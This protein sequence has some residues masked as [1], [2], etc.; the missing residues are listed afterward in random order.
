M[1]RIVIVNTQVPFI[2]GGAEIHAENLQKALIVH[3]FQVEMIRVPFKWYP[4]EKIPEQILACRLF[5]LIESCGE[6]INLLI[7][8]KFPGYYIKHPNKVLWILHQHRPVYD[9]WNT[10]YRDIPDNAEG[11]EI[12]DIIIQSDKN[13]LPEAKKIFTNSKNV[14]SRLKKFNNLD[15]IPLYHPPNNFNKFFSNDFGNYIFYPSRMST[16]KRQELAIE[17]MRF[18]KT[19]VRLILTGSAESENL[20]NFL[21]KGVEKYNLGSKVTFTGSM[22]EDEKIRIYSNAL[23]V[24]FIP[25]DEDY[26]Y[27]T[28][29]AMYSRKPVITCT[30]SGGPLEFVE[31]D[32]TGYIRN[33]VPEEI[34]DAMDKLYLEREKAKKLGQTGYEKII[35]MNI[36]WEK[37]VEAIL[38]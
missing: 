1:K 31:D 5:N 29:E 37:V 8:M 4:P 19:D 36:S 2:T 28:L 23:G 27:V 20:L 17:S 10:K 11:R 24:L 35:S 9:L 7:G 22:A 15:A 32:I 13:F 6:K 3:G 16:L 12:R 30:D 14:A 33:P 26:G 34:A 25:Y 21:K 38:N 18:T